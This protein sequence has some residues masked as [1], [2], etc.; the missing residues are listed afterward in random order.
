MFCL[1]LWRY[2]LYLLDDPDFTVISKLYIE[3][4]AGNSVCGEGE[5]V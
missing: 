1:V 5:G 4:I 2:E 3:L